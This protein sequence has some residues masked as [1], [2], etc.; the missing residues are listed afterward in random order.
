M[1][2][3]MWRQI[4]WLQHSTAGFSV[5]CLRSCTIVGVHICYY[6]ECCFAACVNRNDTE[7]GADAELRR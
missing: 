3:N 6:A 4:T 7:L 5:V 2:D 1:S